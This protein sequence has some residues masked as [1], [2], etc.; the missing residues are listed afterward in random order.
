MRLKKGSSLKCTKKY[1]TT[2]K[3]LI[4]KIR[5]P[6]ATAVI[7]KSGNVV[8]LGAKRK[9]DSRLAARRFARIV[10]KLGFPVRFLDFKIQNLVGTCKTFPLNLEQLALA[11]HEQCSY[12]PE[13]FPGLFYRV[14]P[15]ITATV[16]ATG[17][18]N[19]AGAKEEA[20]IYES[21]DTISQILSSFRR[22]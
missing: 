14:A 1:N 4:M 15:G 16:F 5:K 19:L 9:E 6:R 18:V 13:L 2:F 7:H 3:A 8:C 10:Q 20:E 21:F 17:K 12:E 22:W 11:H